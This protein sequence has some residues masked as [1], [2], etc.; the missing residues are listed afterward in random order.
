[1][2]FHPAA[3]VLRA[4]ICAPH[5]CKGVEGGFS[6]FLQEAASLSSSYDSDADVDTRIV[7]PLI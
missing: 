4:F 6:F 2:L 1:M 3:L 5:L 7:N